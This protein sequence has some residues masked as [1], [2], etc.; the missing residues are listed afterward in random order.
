MA[1]RPKVVDLKNR[2]VDLPNPGEPHPEL[3]ERLEKLLEMAR[4][5]ELTGMAFVYQYRDEGFSWGC[6]GTFARAKI[7]GALHAIA[8]DLTRRLVDE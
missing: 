4:S 8:F 6:A 3:V 1:D 7:V 2:A 5:G